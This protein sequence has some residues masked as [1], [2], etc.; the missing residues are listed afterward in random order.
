MGFGGRGGGG[1]TLVMGGSDY[2]ELQEGGP[3]ARLGVGEKKKM[4]V[5]GYPMR[6]RSQ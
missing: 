2:G 5:R 3:H 4:R 6:T 1:G